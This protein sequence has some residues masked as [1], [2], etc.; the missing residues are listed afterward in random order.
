MAQLVN[1]EVCSGGNHYTLY[2]DDG[3]VVQ[4]TLEELQAAA[5]DLHAV[6]VRAIDTTQPITKAS[7]DAALETAKQAE[8]AKGDVK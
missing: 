6:A 1:W 8:A 7:L 5:I 4:T 2:Y 3:S